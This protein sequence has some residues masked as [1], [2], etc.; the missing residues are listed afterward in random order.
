LHKRR[1]EVRN[2]RDSKASLRIGFIF[3]LPTSRAGLSPA[4]S[5]A[6]ILLQTTFR[7]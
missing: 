6:P 4:I 2:V 3:S 5:Q 7:N 1:R